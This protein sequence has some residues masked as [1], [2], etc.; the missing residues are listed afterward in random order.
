MLFA[1][2]LDPPPVILSPDE[3]LDDLPDDLLLEDP[4]DDPLLD[5]P[6]DDPLPSAPK[7]RNNTAMMTTAASVTNT[8]MR[9][10]RIARRMLYNSYP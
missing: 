9:V 4:L 10:N 1:C 7:R 6:P 5:D 3:T 2:G 8:M